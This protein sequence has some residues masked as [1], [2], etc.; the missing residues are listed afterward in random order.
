MD[1]RVEPVTARPGDDTSSHLAVIKAAWA[2]FDEEEP[3]ASV[4]FILRHSHADVVA[5]PYS[6]EGQVLHGFDEI[7]AFFTE[8]VAAGTR[9]KARAQQFDVEDD[10]V[11]VRGSI[12]LA[13]SDGSFAETQ[14]RW[15]YHFEDGLIDVM[16]W[17]PRAGS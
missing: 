5:L 17:G 7:R 9:I 4:E 1:S 13:R 2:I 3:L 15:Y 6:S 16:G 12:R 11:I 10:S 8:A 14:V